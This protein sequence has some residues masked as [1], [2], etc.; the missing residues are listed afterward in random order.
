[1]TSH[2]RKLPFAARFALIAAVGAVPFATAG[3]EDEVASGDRQVQESIDQS[4]VEANA[5]EGATAKVIST[6]SQATSIQ[7]ASP[8]YR[9]QAQALLGQSSY[10]A[11]MELI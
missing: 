8:L 2:A 4:Y 5:G 6:L 11:A 3:C 1:M 7:S 9:A 10:T